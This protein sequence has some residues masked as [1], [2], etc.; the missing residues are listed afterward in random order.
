MAQP[1]PPALPTAP[2]SVVIDEGSGP[3]VLLLHGFPELPSCW[4]HQV[5]P[6]ARAGYRVIAPYLLG[7]GDSPTPADPAAYTA[8][9]VADAV[10]ATIEAAGEEQAVVVGHDWGASATW[11]TAALRPERVRALAA[12]SVPFTARSQHPPIETLE[13][14]MG[15]HYFYMV[16]F[17]TPGKAEA[18]LSVDPRATLLGAYAGLSG[19]PPPGALAPLPKATGSFPQQLPVPAEP[20]PW[21]DLAVLDEEVELFT[22]TGWTGPLNL[23]RAM[24]LTWHAVP[25]LADT[26]ITCPAAFLAGER[27]LVLAFTPKRS[28]AP[29]WVTDLRIDVTVPGVGH[30]VQQEA[31]E[32]VTEVLLDFLAGL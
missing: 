1:P 24:D 20:P 31:P 16:D 32:L 5:D 4:R 27:D 2:L 11:Q 9:H 28:M 30:W 26:R 14:R 6:L 17:Q 3:L 21:V 23:Y 10:A 25:Q 15:D 19:S 7:Y 8:D 29:P 18:D 13:E 22:R 12:L